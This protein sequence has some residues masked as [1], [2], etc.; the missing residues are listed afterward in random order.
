MLAQHLRQRTAQAPLQIWCCAASTGEE[1]YTLAMTALD[2]ALPAGTRTV[3]WSGRDD[4]ARPVV[5]ELHPAGGQVELGQAGF[6]QHGDGGLDELVEIVR[7]DLAGETDG[8][9]LD[10]LREEQ[11]EF[12]RQ[13]V[14]LF[15]AAVVAGQPD[16]GFRV[17]GVGEIAAQ[18]DFF[19]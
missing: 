6:A 8:D 1:P 16:G 19:W 7:Q 3:E 14:G 10:A 15:P 12:N 18:G 2:A 17:E 11:R 9:T 4:A 5:E 13:R